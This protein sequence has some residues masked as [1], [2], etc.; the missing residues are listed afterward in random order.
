[1]IVVGL[2]EPN[3]RWLHS[4]HHDRSGPVGW[5][6]GDDAFAVTNT[7]GQGGVSVV[8]A[9]TFVGLSEASLLGMPL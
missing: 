9:A 3:L 2:G 1:M 6:I 8:A 4:L 5:K 7:M